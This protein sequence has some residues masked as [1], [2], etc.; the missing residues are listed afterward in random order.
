MKDEVKRII[1]QPTR[2][3]ALSDL[4]RGSKQNLRFPGMAAYHTAAGK[5]SYAVSY[6]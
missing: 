6:S 4:I 5:N 1:L 2:R 3:S